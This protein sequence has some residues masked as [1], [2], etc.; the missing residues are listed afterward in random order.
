MRAALAYRRSRVVANDPALIRKWITVGLPLADSAIALD[1]NSADAYEIRGNLRYWGW[2]SA[3]DTD[4]TKRAAALT[5]ARA[6]LEKSTA[7]NRNQAGAWATLSHLYNQVSDATTNDVYLAAQHALDADEFLSNANTI[8]SRL[9][10]AAYDLGQFDKAKQWCDV[11]GKRFPADMRAVKCQLYLLTTRIEQ[12]DI[13]KAWRLA[14]S[15]VA[16]VAPAVR[17]RERLSE[18]M[19]VAAVIA[20]ASKDQPALADSARHVAKRSEG[21]A[22][23][24]PTRDLAYF[25]SFVYTL[26][27]DTNQAISML[28]QYLAV[29]PTK[30]A[31]MRDDAG[32]WFRGISSDSRFQRAV[33]A[34]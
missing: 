4:P 17:P 3:L 30:A 32:W 6:D 15:A 13:S 8:L 31:S 19:L 28:K 12:P 23:V 1:A 27:G 7:L 33:N 5:A 22:S 25:G 24:D 29:N 2:L 14:D 9:F 10:L 11:A 20:R 26:L 21:D 16:S 34:P 18:D